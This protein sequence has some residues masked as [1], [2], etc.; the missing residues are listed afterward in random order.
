MTNMMLDAALHLA[1]LGIRVAPINGPHRAPPI[2]DW[3]NQATTNPNTIKQWWDTRTHRNL[4]VVCGTQPAGWH[5]T[6]IDIDRKPDG[7]NGAKQLAN[8]TAVYGPLPTTWTATTPT[9][10]RHY[11]YRTPTPVANQQGAGNTLGTAIDIRGQGGYVVAPPS[12]TTDGHYRWHTPPDGLPAVMP[13]WALNI[14]TRQTLCCPNC[15]ST[16]TR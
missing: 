12:H 10:G 11:Y 15:H 3:P 14:I 4:A 13:E 1:N 6:V 2:N 5:L 7:D 8:L 9:G 16:N